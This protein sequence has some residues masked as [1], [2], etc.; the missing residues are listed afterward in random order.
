[1]ATPPMAVENSARH[2]RGWG[3]TSAEI[4]E[5]VVALL[6]ESDL[7]HSVPEVAVF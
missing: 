5:D 2:R 1:M 3:L 7:V 4:T 6:R